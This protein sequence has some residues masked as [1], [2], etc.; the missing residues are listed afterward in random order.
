MRE[1]L[2]NIMEG[3]KKGGGLTAAAVIGLTMTLSSVM[4]GTA[5]AE[6]GELVQRYGGIGAGQIYYYSFSVY[7]QVSNGELRKAAREIEQEFEQLQK[8]GEETGNG[9]QA[10]EAGEPLEISKFSFA[11][12]REDTDELLDA[13]MLKDGERLEP[14][15]GD[16]FV[17]ANTRPVGLAAQNWQPEVIELG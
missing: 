6:T 5:L 13:F 11:F 14:E 1:R 17:S 8:T 12:Y 9:S 2:R 16:I 7:G 4:G 3:K 10:Y 15:E